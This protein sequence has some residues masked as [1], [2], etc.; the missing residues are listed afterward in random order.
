LICR[1]VIA[2]T[3]SI[4]KATSES[5]VVFWHELLKK[6]LLIASAEQK[7][8]HEREYDVCGACVHGT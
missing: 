3:N 5:I 4:E 8:D 6:R 1:C 2:G 7:A